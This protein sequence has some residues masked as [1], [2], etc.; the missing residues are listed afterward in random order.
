MSSTPRSKKIG[1]SEK[2][3]V[4]RVHPDLIFCG[5][6][7]FGSPDDGERWFCGG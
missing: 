2:M 4:K 6:L 1:W 5:G 3:M 7:G